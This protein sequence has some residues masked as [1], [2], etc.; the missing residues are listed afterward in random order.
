MNGAYQVA[1]YIR[2]VEDLALPL[3]YPDPQGRFYGYDRPIRLRDGTIQAGAKQLVNNICLAASAIIAHKKKYHVR[4]KHE[5]VHLYQQ[6]VGDEWA[7]FIK[8]LYEIGRNE[9]VYVI[10]ADETAQRQFRD[11]CRQALLFERHFL[12]IYQDYLAKAI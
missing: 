1:A 10:P 7:T 3:D 6:Q 5:C 4:D 11:F 9:W 12:I 8:D 2:S